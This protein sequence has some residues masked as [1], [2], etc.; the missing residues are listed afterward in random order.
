MPWAK[1]PGVSENRLP[2]T[3]RD[4]GN[5]PMG[6]GK[7]YELEIDK[8]ISFHIFWIPRWCISY[9][10]SFWIRLIIVSPPISL[11]HTHLPD[12]ILRFC[13]SYEELQPRCAVR[14]RLPTL[15][16][17][18]S[19]VTDKMC[20]RYNTRGFTSGFSFPIRGQSR[21]FWCPCYLTARNKE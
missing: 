17:Y 4:T 2:R 7:K 19:D 3:S 12:K 14:R 18:L 10:F 16:I 9:L 5:N 15:F 13:C 11:V 1:C 20:G 8:I 21:L 6:E